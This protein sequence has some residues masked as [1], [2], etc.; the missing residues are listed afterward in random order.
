MTNYSLSLKSSKSGVQAPFFLL[1]LFPT[2]T[3]NTSMEHYKAEKIGRNWCITKDGELLRTIG[4]DRSSESRALEQA[5]ELNEAVEFGHARGY[6]S[7]F[8]TGD[9]YGYDRGFNDGFKG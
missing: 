4:A 9:L 6:K 8:E 5:K 3:V 7:G 1:Q 2:G